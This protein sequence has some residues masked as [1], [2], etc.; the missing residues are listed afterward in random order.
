MGCVSSNG[1]TLQ[2]TRIRL[3]PYLSTY[4]A[5]QTIVTFFHH[6]TMPDITHP[7][8]SANLPTPEEYRKRK[9]ALIS[10]TN[11]PLSRPSFLLPR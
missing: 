10:G 4:I 5:H 11:Y 2:G 8:A 9:V 6:P 3:S 7:F 1:C